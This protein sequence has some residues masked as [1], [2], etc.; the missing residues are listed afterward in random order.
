MN[1]KN[2]VEKRDIVLYLRQ[3]S[4]E[5]L[6]E[7][8]DEGSSKKKSAFSIIFSSKE[9]QKSVRISKDCIEN[10]SKNSSFVQKSVEINRYEQQQHHHHR[11]H[12][13]HIHKKGRHTPPM[14][15]S[16]LQAQ[17]R[18]SNITDEDDYDEGDEDDD[19]DK[20]RQ[21]IDDTQIWNL[22]LF[23]NYLTKKHKQIKFKRNASYSIISL[24][25]SLKNKASRKRTRAQWTKK[26]N[27]SYMVKCRV[28]HD[29]SSNDFQAKCGIA[30]PT[31]ELER[32]SRGNHQI[33][34]ALFLEYNAAQLVC[35]SLFFNM[36]I[37]ITIIKNHV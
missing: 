17:S 31:K 3:I 24:D 22:C 26:T 32:N 7:P 18:R 14:G 1:N 16:R 21:L 8:R 13:Q 29:I 9:K 15:T 11:Q 23:K 37:T 33:V 28:S 12:Y 6:L 36:T 27:R 2:L 4:S 25:S 20:D 34:T 35:F 30:A 5:L 10:M 19:N